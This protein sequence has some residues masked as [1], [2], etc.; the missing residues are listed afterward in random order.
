MSILSARTNSYLKLGVKHARNA[1]DVGGATASDLT[2]DQE[3]TT[4]YLSVQHRL[5]ALLSAGLLTQYQHSVF[6]GGTA[7]GETDDYVSAALT[8]TY[9]VN[10][11]W[12]AEASYYLDHLS[13]Y[14]DDRGFTR[15]RVLIGVRGTY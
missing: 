13:S 3:T 9:K 4:V 6:N 1:T 12:S 7:D 14:S 2:L 8:V 5:T 10:R 11:N 15:N